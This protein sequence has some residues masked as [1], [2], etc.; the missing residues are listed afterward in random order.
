MLRAPAIVL[1]ALV[2]GTLAVVVPA[3]WFGLGGGGS[4]YGVAGGGPVVRFVV[5]GMPFEDRLFK[6]R[7]A[8]GHAELNPHVRVDFQRHSDVQAK[9]NAWFAKGDGA[10]VMRMGIDYYK[11]YADRGMLHP[12]DD[13]I[14]LPE[15]Y[16][17]RPDELAAIPARL[18]DELTIDGTLYALPED[19]AQYGLFYNKAIFDDYNAQHPDDPLA[20]P[21]ATWTWDD[22]LHAAEKLTVR[23]SEGR[24]DVAGLDMA[25]SYA[26]PFHNFYV[27]AG[28][29]IWSADELT[30][31]IDGPAGVTALEMF[32]R[33]V[34][35]GVYEPYFGQEQGTGPAAR[36]MTGRTAMLYDGSWSVPRFQAQAPNL[37]FA[38]ALV[39]RGV[40]PAVPTGSVLWAISAEAEYPREGWRMIRWLMTEQQAAA[41]WQTLRVAPP[42]N[43]NVM[44]S[45]AFR[46]T[47]GI[48]KLDERGE[49]IPGEYEVPPMPRD[50]YEDYAA[51]LRFA[52]QEDQSSGVVPGFTMA[53]RYQKRLDAEIVQLL[54]T[55]L[56]NPADH[57]PAALLRAAAARVHEEIDLDLRARGLEPPTR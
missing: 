46:A 20:Y 57:D 16:G 6:D 40:R 38:V 36:F 42:A 48:P 50:K 25:I 26:W 51:W 21:D 8:A 5:F 43:T 52:W 35:A 34:E 27:Q 41:Y 1:F 31:H 55:W 18:I 32:R 29:A 14:A 12:L 47:T 22:L 15:P 19:S 44:A 11:Q 7:Y 45:E 3:S 53:A 30:T 49:P 54:A 10:E 9:Y 28:G 2:A 33:I 4:G 13:Y 37:D 23:D 17:L 56:R 24:L 39:P